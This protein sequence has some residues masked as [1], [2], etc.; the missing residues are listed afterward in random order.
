MHLKNKGL[1]TLGFVFSFLYLNAQ[2]KELRIGDTVPDIELSQLVNYK[3]KTAKLYDF[4]KDLLIID[5]WATWCTPCIGMF[6]KTDTI[7]KAF[8]HRVQFLPVSYEE[9][10]R[11]SHF[12]RSMNSVKNLHVFSVS[13][14][15]LLR[16]LFRFQ[17]FPHYV[18][19]DSN[20]KVIAITSRS[21]ITMQNISDVLEGK[22]LTL[23]LK[24]DSDR[25]MD[26]RRNAFDEAVTIIYNND[27]SNTNVELIPRD[28][29]QYKSLFTWEVPGIHGFTH[30]EPNSYSSVNGSPLLLL[31]DYYGL[32]KKYDYNIFT[33][34]GDDRTIL[35]VKDTM[36]VYRLC[37]GY[38]R[39][40]HNSRAWKE[41]GEKYG[42][43]YEIVV[44]DSLSIERKEE[45]M[46]QDLRR[47]FLD[48]YKV[49][50]HVEQ[51]RLKQLV[52]RIVS[53]TDSLATS[54]GTPMTEQ[55]RYTIRLAN[56][57]FRDFIRS[58]KGVYR[59]KY[60]IVDETHLFS[61]ID[62]QLEGDLSDYTILNRQLA[63]Y[64]LKLFPEEVDL[65]VLVVTDSE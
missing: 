14:D 7:E 15:T 34:D 55:T 37:G 33:F 41:W 47:Y 60:S 20:A 24:M 3:G 40:L 27:T 19:I 43:C 35:E 56:S 17:S 28:R 8:D 42:I 10:D 21:E 38:L 18:W 1:L 9:N 65:D 26:I 36:T 45:I 49:T 29:V 2:H 59:S 16:Q 31:R 5:F 39:D 44:P 62:L 46:E 57:P 23:P 32:K 52:L 61:R 50:F 30:Y 51:R 6:P 12:L 25:S 4:K 64:G 58:L 63:K 11:V 22:P 13:E 54:G 48:V 53:S